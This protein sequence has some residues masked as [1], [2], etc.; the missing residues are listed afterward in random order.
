MGWT[1]L[2][3]QT[4][5]PSDKNQGLCDLARTYWTGREMLGATSGA[6]VD[7]WNAELGKTLPG[8]VGATNAIKWQTY[9]AACVK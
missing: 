8:Y 3:Q 7:N 4:M 2:M 5:V 6:A 1:A 9:L